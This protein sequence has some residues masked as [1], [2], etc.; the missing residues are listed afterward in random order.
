MTALEQL[1]A[2][3]ARLRALDTVLDWH[4]DLLS[5]IRRAQL[6]FELV[7]FKHEDQDLS[8]EVAALIRICRQLTWGAA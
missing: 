7:D 4:L 6:R 3:R 1:D 8:G 2:S 5:R